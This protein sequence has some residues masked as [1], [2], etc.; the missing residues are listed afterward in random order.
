[1]LITATT[2][3]PLL[4]YSDIDQPFNPEY[5][6]FIGPDRLSGKNNVLS[7]KM[8]FRPDIWQNFKKKSGYQDFESMFDYFTTLCTKGLR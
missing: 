6:L 1:M 8:N 4:S 5:N 2:S 7:D 3:S